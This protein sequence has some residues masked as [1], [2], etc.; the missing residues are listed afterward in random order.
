[1][2]DRGNLN[3]DKY[4]F[5]VTVMPSENNTI[6]LAAEIK[7]IN[8]YGLR[9]N[10]SSRL[11]V[12]RTVVITFTLDE[13]EKELSF[14]GEVIWVR[15]AV[16]KEM[17]FDTRIEFTFLSEE[18]KFLLERFILASDKEIEEDEVKRQNK[19]STKLLA[20]GKGYSVNAAEEKREELMGTIFFVIV[21]LFDLA[22]ILVFFGAMWQY[23]NKNVTP[24]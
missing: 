16:V 8:E 5:T 1:M 10:L 23:I 4:A 2:A 12:G 15:S 19:E 14:L 22:V 21:V 11:I 18:S 6:K 7:D 24:L 3:R 17:G 9:V 20:S 13:G